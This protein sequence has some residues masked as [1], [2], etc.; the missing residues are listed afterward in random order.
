[1]WEYTGLSFPKGILSIMHLKS[2]KTGQAVWPTD[3]TC[4]NSH[5]GHNQRRAQIYKQNI[6]IVTWFTK[7]EMRKLGFQVENS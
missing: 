3:S 2:L 7:I 6:F 1:M 4:R 5:S